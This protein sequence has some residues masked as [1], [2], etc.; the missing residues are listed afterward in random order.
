MKTDFDS[1]SKRFCNAAGLA[2]L[3]AGL[4]P[5]APGWLIEFGVIAA[6][7]GLGFMLAHE[8]TGRRRVEKLAVLRPA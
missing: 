4:F 1:L 8:I 3:L 2:I 6:I 7:A 5:L